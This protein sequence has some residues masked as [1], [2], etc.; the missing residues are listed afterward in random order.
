MQ[1]LLEYDSRSLE[2]WHKNQENFTHLASMFRDIYVVSAF[3]TGVEYKFSKSGRATSWIRLRL[4]FETISKAIMYKSYLV[5]QRES[6][7]ELENDIRTSET[8]VSE[9]VDI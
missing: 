1:L 8:D 2:S 5:R 7:K 9:E 6:I 4:D 3:K